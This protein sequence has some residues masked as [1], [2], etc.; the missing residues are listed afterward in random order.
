MLATSF[1][2]SS[3]TYSRSP[4]ALPHYSL[5]PPRP[6]PC[7]S[8]GIPT[9]QQNLFFMGKL[10]HNGCTLAD[11]NIRMD[12]T[13][14]LT[15]RLKGSIGSWIPPSPDSPLSP[16]DHLLLSPDPWTR[17]SHTPISR[18][19]VEAIIASAA[20][21]PP[22]PL[23]LLPSDGHTP[24]RGATGMGFA[25][26]CGVLTSP[27]CTALVRHLEEGFQSYCDV[28]N[29]PDGSGVWQ[30]FQVRRDV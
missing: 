11:Y 26:H 5:F 22:P 13:L 15:L 8:S 29:H 10:L 3:H 9:D 27:Q 25:K 7:S 4:V 21:P 30:M 16:A 20:G 2:P 19:E 12:S 23:P 17:V 6:P 1:T 14:H 18:E 24:A 28:N